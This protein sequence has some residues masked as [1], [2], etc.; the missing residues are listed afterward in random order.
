MTSVLEVLHI[1]R[2]V[3]K[4]IPK[5]DRDRIVKAVREGAYKKAREIARAVLK[6]KSKRKTKRKRKKKAEWWT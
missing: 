2:E 4:S 6:R 5:R 1:S 3:W